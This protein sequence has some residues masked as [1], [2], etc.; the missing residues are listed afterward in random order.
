MRWNEREHTAIAI[1]CAGELVTQ[2]CVTRWMFS[3]TATGFL[4]ISWFMRCTMIAHLPSA[5][6]KDG[7][8]RIVDMTASVRCRRGITRRDLKMAR[9]C[10]KIVSGAHAQS[11]SG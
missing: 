4:K 6:M 10:A 3:I 11:L 2:V 5:F 7:A 1:G 8:I 9:D